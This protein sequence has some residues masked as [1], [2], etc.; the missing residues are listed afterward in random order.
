MSG[1]LGC[2]ERYLRQVFRH[3][4][5]LSPAD[6]MKCE[7]MVEARHRLREGGDLVELT[8]ELGFGSV[9]SFGRAF[10]ETY[11]IAP[12]SYQREEVRR[13]GNDCSDDGILEFQS[14]QEQASPY[15]QRADEDPEEPERR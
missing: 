12:K 2:S 10:K 7:R 9:S 6:W 8:E 11:G 13:C 3:D 15:P 5:G 4:V 14:P 1:E